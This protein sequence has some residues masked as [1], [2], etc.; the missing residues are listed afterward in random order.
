VE[1]FGQL[2]HWMYCG[3]IQADKIGLLTA[4]KLWSIA[5]RFMIPALQN[6]VMNKIFK[7]L[8]RHA[9]MGYHKLPEDLGAA[10]ELAYA[11]IVDNK[12][13]KILAKFVAACF[14]VHSIRS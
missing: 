13:K 14:D 3:K 6:F 4:V 10:F 8:A 5:A 11:S 2:V 12:L 1:E 7:F 9:T